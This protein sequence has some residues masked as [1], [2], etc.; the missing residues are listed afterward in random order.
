M[1]LLSSYQQDCVTRDGERVRA[2]VATA[3][4]ETETAPLII[5]VCFVQLCMMLL[6]IIIFK[7]Y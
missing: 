4:R 2:E 7:K 5:I 6:I 1:W 3:I